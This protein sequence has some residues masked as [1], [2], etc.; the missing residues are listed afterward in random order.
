[1]LGGCAGTSF[2]AAAQRR[3]AASSEQ[4]AAA[5]PK[6]FLTPP[7]QTIPPRNFRVVADGLRLPEGPIAMPDGSILFVEIEAEQLSRL[8]PDGGIEVV[9]SIPGGPNGVAIGPDGG[10][11]VTNNGGFIWAPVPGAGAMKLPTGDMSRYRGGS[12]ERVDLKT[13]EHRT[14]YDS[15]EGQRLSAPNDLVFDNDGGFYFT[16]WGKPK[17]KT[18]DRGAVYH[19]RADGSALRRIAFPLTGPNGITLSPDAKILYV[20]QSNGKILSARVEPDKP[21]SFS[22]FAAP[23]GNIEFDGLTVEADGSVLAATN[24]NGGIIR[25]TP[26]GRTIDYTPLPDYLTTNVAFGGKDLRTCYV[27]LSARGQIAA[28]DWPRPG[29]APR[30]VR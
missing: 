7:V 2:A 16:D 22:V 1:M 25:V 15:F 9:A 14:L 12:I 18:I 21:A 13:G 3:I 26:D 20:G 10:A 17:D 30:Y 11:Y 5:V 8:R 29:L 28:I 19:A 6:V 27:T 23:G 4:L 24:G